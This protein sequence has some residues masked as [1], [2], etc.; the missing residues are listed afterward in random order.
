MQLQSLEKSIGGEPAFDSQRVAALRAAI[1]EGRYQA[2]P[3]RI[4]SKMLGSNPPLA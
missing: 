3:E 2:D 4:A 1:A